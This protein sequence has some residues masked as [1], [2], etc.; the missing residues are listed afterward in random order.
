MPRPYEGES[1][2]VSEGAARSTEEG[3]ECQIVS[4]FAALGAH[5][6]AWQRLWQSHPQPE[7]FQSFTWA[8]AW[9]QSFG[10]GR[11]LR[12]PIVYQA[13]EVVLILPLV[14]RR[15]V[16]QFLGAPEADYCDM[17]CSYPQPAQA[18]SVALQGLQKAAQS[19]RECILQ[20]LRHDS[21]FV[22]A[23]EQLPLELRRRIQ[24]QITDTC[25]TIK[26]GNDR[27]Q[28]V[29]ALLTSKHLRR[30]LR[31]LQKS[32]EVRFRHMESREEVQEQLTQFFRCHRRR[33]VLLAKLSCFE[34]PAM[35]RLMRILA[36]QLDP[37]Q[38]LRFG[39]LE[40]NG[41]P[42]AWSL[43][44]Q[45]HGKYAYYQQTFDVDAE[46]YA[47]GE[48]LL[49]HL[50]AYANEAVERE[51][52]FLRGDEFFKRRFATHINPILTGYFE[53][54]GLRGR[55]RWLD[56]AV[57]SQLG[58]IRRRLVG[59]VRTHQHIFHVF[60][61]TWV[62]RRALLR[63]LQ[64]ARTSGQL[65]S[66]LAGCVYDWF[67]HAVWRSQ[68]ATTF[69]QSGTAQTTSGAEPAGAERNI[70][71]ASGRFSD[72]ADVALEHPE[73]PF[74]RFHEYRTRLKNGHR[75]YL[76]R[77]DGELALVAWVRIQC[78][79]N[80]IAPNPKEAVT[81]YECWPI[82]NP[83]PGCTCLLSLLAEQASGA[84]ADVQIHC[85]EVPGKSLVALHRQGY[86]PA[87]RTVLRTLLHLFRIVRRHNESLVLPRQKFPDDGVCPKLRGRSLP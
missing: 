79:D 29:E 54:P 37:R 27:R 84:K 75:V 49:Y 25:P 21:D 52:D 57:D 72:L 44:F 23:C 63:R 71:I 2:S 74:P 30:R 28:V 51:L 58:G 31:K 16:L 56:R 46:E 39:V 48:M 45:L 4:D 61:A 81:M 40:R 11:R 55:L 38:E 87:S 1:P 7:I 43:G 83:G 53:R 9:W 67:R 66:Y 35:R 22:Q 86:A 65:T 85:P 3:F 5:S 19:W 77:Q 62:W 80:A 70:T 82:R 50:L 24:L 13:G 12:V 17:L 47:P 76:V 26:L 41:Q 78:T 60:R 73:I 68:V 64:W 42:L 34:D 32:G 6:T 69:M 33:C 15:G 14:Q 18:L 20:N 59:F 36:A 8:Q 10:Q